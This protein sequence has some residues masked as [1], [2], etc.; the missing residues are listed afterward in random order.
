MKKFLAMLTCALFILSLFTACANQ[1]LSYQE[2]Q[3]QEFSNQ[4]SNIH[5]S[6]LSSYVPLNQVTGNA[7]AANSNFLNTASSGIQCGETELIQILKD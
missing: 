5:I 2:K 7:S 4:S 3:A 1:S 6:N